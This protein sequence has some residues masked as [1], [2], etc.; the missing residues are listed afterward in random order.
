MLDKKDKIIT[1]KLYSPH[2]CDYI[3]EREDGSRYIMV[4]RHDDEYWELVPNPSGETEW[5]YGERIK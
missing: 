4:R 3:C 1:A 2:V 5:M